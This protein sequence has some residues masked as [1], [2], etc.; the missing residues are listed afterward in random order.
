NEYTV[1]VAK[2]DAPKNMLKSRLWST[3]DQY[4]YDEATFKSFFPN[5]EYKKEKDKETWK[6]TATTF[7]RS[8]NGKQQLDLIALKAI[9]KNGWYLIDISTKDAKGQE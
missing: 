5:D 6:E 4:I 2:L 3:P 1:K 8:Y 9:T 7:S